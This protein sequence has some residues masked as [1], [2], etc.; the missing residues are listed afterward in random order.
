PR[1]LDI[2]EDQSS[3]PAL[4]TIKE[5]RSAS[6]LPESPTQ[7]GTAQTPATVKELAAPPLP[8]AP[9]KELAAPPLAVAPKKELAAPPLPVAPKL[10]GIVPA[11]IAAKE[12]PETRSTVAP[13]DLKESTPGPTPLLAA[14][15]NPDSSSG[16]QSSATPVVPPVTSEAERALLGDPPTPEPQPA[17]KASADPKPTTPTA[18]AVAPAA[19]KPE[20]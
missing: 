10:V 3:G 5:L 17:D 2:T 19:P 16:A 12:N 15:P 7:P 9:R 14:P 11:M 20:F 4:V 1:D 13:K 8:V 18:A 6:P